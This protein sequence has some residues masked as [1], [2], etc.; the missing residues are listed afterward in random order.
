[1]EYTT[2]TNLQWANR[3]HTFFRCD[4]NFV[5]LGVLPF[6]PTANDP[7]AHGRE[8]Y[9]RCMAG[10]FGPIADYVLQPDEY[11]VIIS[12]A[13]PQTQGSQTL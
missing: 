9:A 3:E 4:V 13:T 7:E 2:V 1:M 12:R 6:C 5:A 11:P 8:I 10:E